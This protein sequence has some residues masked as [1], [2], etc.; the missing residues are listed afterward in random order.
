MIGINFFNESGHPAKQTVVRCLTDIL[1][2]P[3]DQTAFDIL[4]D[5]LNQYI[6]TRVR[7]HFLPINNVQW[8]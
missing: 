4:F 2:Q 3:L 5:A 7:F 6:K 1:L 8:F